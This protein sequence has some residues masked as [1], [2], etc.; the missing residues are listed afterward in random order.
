MLRPVWKSRHHCVPTRAKYAAWR[1]KTASAGAV[2]GTCGRSRKGLG[3]LAGSRAFLRE[4]VDQ[5]E[6]SLDAVASLGYTTPMRF[7]ALRELKI[8][9][10]RT[11]DRLAREDIVVTRNGKPAAALIRLDED[12]LEDFV[13]ARSPKLWKEIQAAQREYLKKGGIDHATMRRRIERRR[14]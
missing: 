10:S 7:V 8:Q 9:P 3:R 13:L 12:L 4:A 2:R 6:S 1:A 11:L 5:D 14:G